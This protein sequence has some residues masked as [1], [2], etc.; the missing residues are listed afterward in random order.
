MKKNGFTLMELLAVIAIIGILVLLIVP[1]VLKTYNESII[2]SLEVEEGVIVDAAN[3][4]LEDYCISP[5]DDDHSS[6]CPSTYK[7]DRYLA[8]EDL[9]DYITKELKYKGQKCNGIVI[10]NEK[11]EGKTYLA[12]GSNEEDGYF[13]DINIYDGNNIKLK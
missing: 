6:Q 9:K 11:K 5:I 10:Y 4:F 13:T 1:N 2:K 8:L 12:C 7:N 3:I